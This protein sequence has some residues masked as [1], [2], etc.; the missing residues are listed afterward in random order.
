MICKNDYILLKTTKYPV[1]LLKQNI[2][3]NKDLSNA[4]NQ[5]LKQ[6]V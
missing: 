1:L 4:D 2:I 5:N 3:N 6:V